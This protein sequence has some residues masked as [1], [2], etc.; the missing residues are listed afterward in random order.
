MRN[1][2]KHSTLKK[3]RRRLRKSRLLPIVPTL[4]VLGPEGIEEWGSWISEKIVSLIEWTI[5]YFGVW[6][7]R[8]TGLVT[9]MLDWLLDRQQWIYG[10][11]QGAGVTM[12]TIYLYARWRRAGRPN[13]LYVVIGLW[14]YV[15]ITNTICKVRV[16]YASCPGGN[17]ESTMR[18]RPRRIEKGKPERLRFDGNVLLWSGHFAIDIPAIYRLNFGPSS[19]EWEAT[20]ENGRRR[21]RGTT[22]GEEARVSPPVY[23]E[24]EVLPNRDVGVGWQAVQLALSSERPRSWCHLADMG[25]FLATPPDHPKAEHRRKKMLASAPSGP[26]LPPKPD[27]WPMETT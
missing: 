17:G 7:T 24:I 2:R 4:L 15:R 10:L 14:K 12:G 20:V 9:P 6:T 1:T 13:L 3:F 22:Y 8:G 16:R 21:Y 26:G 25:W 18:W 27:N 11:M 19:V 23:I 5:P